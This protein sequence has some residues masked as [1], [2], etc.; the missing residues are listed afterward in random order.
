MLLLRLV[1][2]ILPEWLAMPKSFPTSNLS[3]AFKTAPLHLFWD[4][5]LTPA[6]PSL[7]PTQFPHLYL[8]LITTNWNV[9]FICLSPCLDCEVHRAGTVFIGS[10]VLPQPH[11]GFY[12]S[13]VNIGLITN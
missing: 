8:A 9:P 12:T 3:P 6:L 4:M 10:T 2:D 5:A 11:K 7:A 1:V 13:M